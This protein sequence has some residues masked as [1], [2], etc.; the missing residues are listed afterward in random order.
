MPA[1]GQQRQNQGGGGGRE[2]VGPSRT[3]Q[4]RDFK[5]GLMNSGSRAGIPDE[6]LWESTNVQVIGPGQMMTLADPAA[7]IVSLS[8]AAVSLW[9]VMLALG[10]VEVARLVAIHTDGSIRLIDPVNGALTVIAGAGVWSS[11]GRL[12]MWRDSH[13]LFV[14]PSKGYASWDG[15]AFIKYPGTFTAS[16]TNASSVLTW[17]GGTIPA[18]SVV[19]GMGVAGT[20]IPA[21]TT[22]LSTAGSSITMTNAATATGSI[23]VTVGTSAP[24]SC[25]DVA[26]FEGRV[27]LVTGNRGITFTGPGSFTTFET[28]YAGGATTMP[29]SVFPGAI[30]RLIA[31]IQLLWVYGPNA[32]NTISNVQVNAGVTTFQNENVVTGTGAGSG[33]ADSI[34]PVY[35]S[36]VHFS[37]TGIYV[38]LGATPQKISDQLDTLMPSVTAVGSSPGAVFTLNGLLVYGV[39]VNVKG[40]RR[41]L[42][43]SRP[44]WLVGEQGADLIWI[45]TLV[46]TDGDI[47]AWGTNGTTVR[48]LFAGTTGSYDIRLK[49]FDFGQFTRRDTMRRIAVEADFV[50]PTVQIAGDIQVE[51]ENQTATSDPLPGPFKG[52]VSWISDTFRPVTWINVNSGLVTWFATGHLLFVAPVNFS[53]NLLSCHIYG[54]NSVKLIIGGVAFEIGFGGEWTF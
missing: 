46:R 44:T 8:P 37:P 31:A 27:W 11:D 17:T 34:Q 13:L 48:R 39:L 30:T 25:R 45:T 14:S 15:T 36:L 5:K 43:Y 2:G 28:V 29:D 19:A 50:D 24:T 32:I 47:Q 4:Y 22:V 49:A 40:V 9:G 26:V 33:S 53:G 35:R 18:A 54:R 21:G 23:T 51:A 20:G 6:A 42:I 1:V 52:E 12:T 10:G 41:L 7:S 3:I 16:T 38:I